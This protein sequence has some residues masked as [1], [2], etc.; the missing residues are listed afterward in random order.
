MATEPGSPPPCSARTRICPLC[1][2]PG[3]DV[4]AYQASRS[5]NGIPLR[6]DFPAP[7]GVVQPPACGR[8]RSPACGRLRCRTPASGFRSP[9]RPPGAA[10]AEP[11]AR[12]ASGGGPGGGLRD[13]SWRPERADGARR[14]CRLRAVEDAL[15]PRHLREPDRRLRPGLRDAGPRGRGDRCGEDRCD[16]PEGSSRRQSARKGVPAGTRPTG[17]RSGPPAIPAG[18]GAPEAA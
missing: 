4:A 16:A 11:A 1:R 8:L 13:R 18:S 14:A 17:P 10:A 3:Q 6:S 12:R 9:V 7:R 15:E 2:T 5:M